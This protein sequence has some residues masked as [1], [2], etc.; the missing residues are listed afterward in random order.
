MGRWDVGDSR[1][2]HARREFFAAR[3]LQ[4]VHYKTRCEPRF[5]FA[6]ATW[7]GG[8]PPDPLTPLTTYYSEIQEEDSF[9]FGFIQG[10]YVQSTHACS[11]LYSLQGSNLC[12]AVEK[13]PRV[14]EVLRT[15]MAVDAAALGGAEQGARRSAR[16]MPSPVRSPPA[17]QQQD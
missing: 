12:Y 15:S 14:V 2:A 16:T 3:R 6:A 7:S 4:Y 11:C 17:I 1:L 10:I 5:D 13:Q 9:L 8:A